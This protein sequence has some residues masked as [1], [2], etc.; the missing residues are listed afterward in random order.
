MTLDPTRVRFPWMKFVSRRIN[1]AL[2]CALLLCKSSAHADDIV[3]RVTLFAD[4]ARAPRTSPK[5]CRCY[6]NKNG[7]CSLRSAV[8]AANGCGQHVRIELPS[9]DLRLDRQGID[10]D[11]AAGDLDVTGDM[12]IVGHVDGTR[13]STESVTLDRMFDVRPQATLR[14]TDVALSG[15]GSQPGTM[16]RND[17][18][19]QLDHVALRGSIVP[20]EASGAVFSTGTL[21]LHH[22]SVNMILGAVPPAAALSIN[23]GDVTLRNTTIGENFATGLRISSVLAGATL[24]MNNVTIAKNQG[25]GDRG[26]EVFGPEPVTIRASNTILAGNGGGACIGTIESVGANFIDETPECVIAG[27]RT[28]DVHGDALLRVTGGEWLALVPLPPN[29]AIDAGDPLTCEVDDQAGRPR[30]VGQGCDIGAVEAD[31]CGDGIVSGVEDC[32][33]PQDCC[34]AHCTFAPEGATCP[35]SDRCQAYACDARGACVATASPRECAQTASVQGNASVRITYGDPS[36]TTMT[37]RYPAPRNRWAGPPS[38]MQ[39]VMLCFFAE[40]GGA[41]TLVARH[42]FEGPWLLRGDRRGQYLEN[43]SWSVRHPKPGP[44]VVS[45]SGSGSPIGDIPHP[46][47]DDTAL[48]IIVRD[49]HDRCVSTLFS[50]PKRNDGT[51]FEAVTPQP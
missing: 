19:L 45:V 25:A 46:L 3:F 31:V 34:S 37:W 48:R 41:A 5:R 11:S 51:R 43:G 29:P 30:P 21:G 13:I 32:E 38:G 8:R 10:D 44:R 26:I 2:T 1:I 16:I 9:G 14:V 7:D 24:T 50:A 42:A 39:D 35:G 22:S 18:N 17:G 23:G 49:R 40:S 47:W 6:V 15:F 28:G 33:L 27:P 36:D 4:D 20:A 12:E